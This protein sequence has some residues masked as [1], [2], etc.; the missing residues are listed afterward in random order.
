MKLPIL[1]I[2]ILCYCLNTQAQDTP[3]DTLQPS[4]TDVVMPADSTSEEEESEDETAAEEE[5]KDST[6]TKFRYRI[7]VDGTYTS[8]NVE[9]A[10]VQLSSGLEWNISKLIKLQSNPSYIYGQQNK[11]LT[12][13]ETF[14][15]LRTSILH[16]RKLY[17]L[18][19]TSFE[20]SNLRRIN[21]RFVGAA[22]LGL[23][24][25]QKANAY[26]SATNVLLYE[27]TDFVVNEKFPDRNLWRNSTRL[28]GEY[29]LHDKKFSFSHTLFLQPSITE[30]NFRWNGNVILKYQLS[31]TISLRST[32]ENSYESVVVPGRK[33]NDFRLTFGVAYEGKR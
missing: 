19:F 8:G 1:L 30:K 33:N 29:T 27:K 31:K 21:N 13:R 6:P 9:R 11:I 14:I 25:L 16:E 28:F 17:Y 15:D 26:I 3:A 2:T 32:V 20:K 12:E 7:P 4:K 10:L 18:A 5:E 23:K 22:G 24:I